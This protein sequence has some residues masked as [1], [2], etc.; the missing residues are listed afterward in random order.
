MDRGRV[1]FMRDPAG[2]PGEFVVYHQPRARLTDMQKKD[3]ISVFGLNARFHAEQVHFMSDEH[4]S[5]LLHDTLRFDALVGR[6]KRG[7]EGIVRP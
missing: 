2:G 6:K 7:G 5:R 4:E 1:V 3:V